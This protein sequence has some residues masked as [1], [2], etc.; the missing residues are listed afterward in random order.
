M[1]VHWSGGQAVWP[2]CIWEV[3]SQ[4]SCLHS[5]SISLFSDLSSWAVRVVPVQLHSELDERPS[6]VL[7]GLVQRGYQLW[8]L[9]IPVS[10]RPV[11]QGGFCGLFKFCCPAD[12]T[13]PLLTGEAA[14]LGFVRKGST[15]AVGNM[16]G[17][18][19]Q[20]TKGKHTLHTGC[21][22]LLVDLGSHAHPCFCRPCCGAVDLTCK[23]LANTH[24]ISRL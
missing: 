14:V 20:S 18:K 13:R 4:S 17:Q 8:T 23:S 24:V 12:L 21:R 7:L 3:K 19:Q 5:Q 16:Q 15:P 22:G 6:T 1:G 9:H 11:L 10:Q 2:A